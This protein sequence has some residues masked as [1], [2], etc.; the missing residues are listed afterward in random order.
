MTGG[1]GFDTDDEPDDGTPAD[2]FKLGFAA[3]VATTL[4]IGL[5][6]AILTTQP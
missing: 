6:I 2:A 3:G 5:L 4:L 1:A